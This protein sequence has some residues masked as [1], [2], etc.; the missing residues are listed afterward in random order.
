VDVKVMHQYPILNDF[1][2][3]FYDDNT[4]P[5]EL[6][7]EIENIKLGK[8]PNPLVISKIC[9]DI[10]TMMISIESHL[11]FFHADHKNPK[12]L[13]DSIMLFK[14][15]L[16]DVDKTKFSPSLAFLSKFPISDGSKSGISQLKTLFNRDN[17]KICKLYLTL[18]ELVAYSEHYV[19]V[20]LYNQQIMKSK[21]DG[22]TSELLDL[23]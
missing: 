10:Y 1:V 3:S 8:E 14:S 11:T 18:Q 5:L 21:L 6:Q 2:V 9:S 16:N 23:L 19:S 17:E 12:M 13:E 15:L 20:K 4:T 7:Q 22:G